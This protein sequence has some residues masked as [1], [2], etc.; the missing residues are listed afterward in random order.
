MTIFDKIY[1]LAKKLSEALVN[2]KDLQDLEDVDFLS[3]EAKKHIVQHLS[4]AEIK[5][6]LELLNE[7][8]KEA[9]WAQIEK[10]ISIHGQTNLPKYLS[11]TSFYK[12]AAAILLLVSIIY[13]T[14]NSGSD[15]ALLEDEQVKISAG[16]DKA[17]LTLG[18]GS[19]VAL[20]KTKPF[21]NESVYSN[22]ERLDYDKTNT[23]S[24]I[25]FNYLTIPRGGQYQIILSDS[26]MVWL[27]ADS[28]L[29]YPV[30][31]KKGEPRTIELLYG[32]AYFDVSPSTKHQ[33]DV[34]RV[35]AKDQ[36]V[37][38][39]GTEFNIKAY[40]DENHIYTTLV[41]GRVNIVVDENRE[42]LNPGEQSVWNVGTRNITK[43]IVDV[44]YDIAWVRGYFNFR[45]KPLKDI[46]KVLSR[47]YDV[48]ISFE[49][50]ELKEV[51]FSGLLNKEQSIET[52]LD[53]IKNTKFIN[54]YE[55]KN[56]TI[57]IK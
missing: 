40:N 53:G 31:F 44:N 14:F 36:E 33:G 15:N 16:T 38:V 51:K 46:M 45:K 37:E 25:V 47:W 22:G 54:A 4:D 5:D 1:K 26:T 18:D 6:N 17:I 24:K 28:K 23:D 42:Q 21:E 19:E 3:D 56:K 32:E 2:N 11:A 41:E 39:V 48:D 7:I 12:V 55:I 13:I 29:K 49:K 35:I 27:N 50:H 57:T 8:D 9:G 43:H 10:G 20:E 34:F 30:A 52:I